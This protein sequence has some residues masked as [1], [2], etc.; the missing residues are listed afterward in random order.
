MNERDHY[1]LLR[2]KDI[3]KRIFLGHFTPFGGLG[4]GLAAMTA[5]LDARLSSAGPLSTRRFEIVPLQAMV[6]ET[7]ILPCTFPLRAAA[8]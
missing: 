8:G 2:R 6:K 3:A 7:P 5:D 4:N 1:H